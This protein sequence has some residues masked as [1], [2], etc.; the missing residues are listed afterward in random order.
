[1]PD[2][3]GV[4]LAVDKKMM[5]ELP[6]A[7]VA[8]VAVPQPSRQ[9]ND[10]YLEQPLASNKCPPGERERSLNQVVLG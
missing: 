4:A 6:G 5:S 1:M 10:G 7:R 8:V 3:P 9:S 2:V